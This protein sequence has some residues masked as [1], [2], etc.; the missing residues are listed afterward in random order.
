MGEYHT[1]QLGLAGG[2]ADKR[3]AEVL[4]LMWQHC[5]SSTA[6]SVVEAFD[7]VAT[8]V[9]VDL[10]FFESN[11]AWLVIGGVTDDWQ[12]IYTI[13]VTNDDQWCTFAPEGGYVAGTGAFGVAVVTDVSQWNDSS[14]PQATAN[15]W[16]SSSDL[17]G[18]D[19]FRVL[20]SEPG[21][22]IV[23][24]SSRIGG[25][26]AN[27]PTSNTKPRLMLARIPRIGVQ[28]VL[29]SWGYA[30]AGA[31]CLNRHPVEYSPVTTPLVA[32]GYA[33]VGTAEQAVSEGWGKDFDGSFVFFPIYVYAI[34]GYC[35]GHLGENECW[36][37]DPA[38]GHGQ[39]DATGNY[40]AHY[41]IAMR[42]T[43]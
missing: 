31:S 40:Q 38:V 25:Y 39:K 17:D 5:A 10:T 15:I 13:N 8:G 28:G 42:I 12:A 33:C 37:V 18:Y 19:W 11:A 34:T 27:N 1:K 4:F 32:A 36:G 21:S 14:E 29:N 24:Q 23:L 41:D 9:P 2:S 30:V 20:L 22:A 6:V 43:V 7:G 16:I 26:I 3:N 35:L